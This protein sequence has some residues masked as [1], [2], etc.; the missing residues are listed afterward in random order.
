MRMFPIRLDDDEVRQIPWAM[1]EEHSRQFAMNFG[2]RSMEHIASFERGI[3]PA[4]ALAVL[5]DRKYERMFMPGA[6]I[7][8][9]QA[10][11]EW[12]N[13]GATPSFH[14][15]DVSPK[16]RTHIFLLTKSAETRRRL[17]LIR[18]GQLHLTRSHLNEAITMLEE[19]ERIA[20]GQDGHVKMPTST[21]EAVAMQ[22][23]STAWLEGH[24]PHVLRRTDSAL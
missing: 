5:E 17:E 23:L 19:L 20:Q 13:R 24:A 18:D 21:D 16:P 4:Q 15:L 2:G 22:L 11:E 9:K 1:L 10:V 7:A 6:A 8:L 3:T 12:L 14:T